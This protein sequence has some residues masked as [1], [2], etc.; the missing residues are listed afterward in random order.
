M[1]EGRQ[2]STQAWRGPGDIRHDYKGRCFLAQQP[3]LGEFVLQ[4]YL[5]TLET[6][7]VHSYSLWHSL[8]IAKPWEKPKWISIESWSNQLLYVHTVKHETTRQKKEKL[9]VEGQP[10]YTIKWRQQSAEV[11]IE[12]RKRCAWLAQYEEETPDLGS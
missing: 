10:G 12:C 6:M 4:L 5:H 3:Y 1:P 8:T 11:Y 7:D 9:S 2:N